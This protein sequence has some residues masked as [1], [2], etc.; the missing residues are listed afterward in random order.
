MGPQCHEL[1]LGVAVIR[2]GVEHCILHEDADC[3]TYEG[4]EE[5]N[6]DV[7]ACAV[8]TPESCVWERNRERDMLRQN[9]LS[10]LSVEYYG[11]FLF[12]T[13]NSRGWTR[14]PSAM[15][16]KWSS[17]QCT[18]DGASWTPSEAKQ[19]HDQSVRMWSDAMD[20]SH[21]ESQRGKTETFSTLNIFHVVWRITVIQQI[22]ALNVFSQFVSVHKHTAFNQLQELTPSVYTCRQTDVPPLGSC[23]WRSG[24]WC[25]RCSWPMCGWCWALAPSSQIC[26]TGGRLALQSVRTEW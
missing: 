24:M 23:G 14:P 20:S 1:R 19:K 13:W 9:T 16:V 10:T 12:L 8:Q 21:Q 4:G 7:I 11:C 26:H 2:Y 5:V 6:V 25:T 15:P 18:W 17:R 3:S 22:A